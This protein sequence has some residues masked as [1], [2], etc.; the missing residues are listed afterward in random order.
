MIKFVAAEDFEKTATGVCEVRVNGDTFEGN[1]H[2]CPEEGDLYIE[3]ED[4]E[5]LEE[6]QIMLILA[7]G[8]SSTYTGKVKDGLLV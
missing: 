1:Y 8:N 2:K 3:V 4:P 5:F 6:E 7:D